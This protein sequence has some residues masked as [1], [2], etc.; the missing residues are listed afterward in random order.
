MTIQLSNVSPRNSYWKY[1]S[2]VKNRK[3]CP[4]EIYFWWTNAL[5]VVESEYVQ[6]LLAAYPVIAWCPMT[7]VWLGELVTDIARKWEELRHVDKW[8]FINVFDLNKIM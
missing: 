6:S 1:S 5:F 7:G 4:Y 8:C 3:I 2:T